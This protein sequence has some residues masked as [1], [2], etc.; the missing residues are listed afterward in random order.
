MNA[1]KK[2]DVEGIGGS[3]RGASLNRRALRAAEELM[4]PSMTMQ[5]VEIGD[6]PMYNFD[7]HQAGFPAP[8]TRLCERIKAADAV[9]IASPEHNGSM[10]AALKNVI[11]WMSRFKPPPFVN[12]PCAVL[13]P[14]RGP[15]A[16]GRVQYGLRRS[17]SVVHSL[18]MLQPEE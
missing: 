8:V 6:L 9:L 4:P 17:I 12:M 16:G 7:L 18:S 1:T 11:D 10:P 14:S 2:L 3:L 5:V 15:L 13:S